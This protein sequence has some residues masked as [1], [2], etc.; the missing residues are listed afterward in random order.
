MYIGETSKLSLRHRNYLHPQSDSLEKYEV[1]GEL[2]DY[3]MRKKARGY[4]IHF[5]VLDIIYSRMFYEGKLEEFCIG[6][7]WGEHPHYRE[8]IEGWLI[9][10]ARSEYPNRSLNIHENRLR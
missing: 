3:F 9:Q 2:H 7:Q 1:T 8:T 10:F 6:T 4:H 5:Y